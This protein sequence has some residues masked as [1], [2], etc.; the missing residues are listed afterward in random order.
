MALVCVLFSELSSHASVVLIYKIDG[1]CITLLTSSF[2]GRDLIFL[3]A[4][5]LIVFINYGI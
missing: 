2:P 3:N 1:A 4:Q 5:F